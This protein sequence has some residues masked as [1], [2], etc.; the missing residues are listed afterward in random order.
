LQAC[1]SDYVLAG[2]VL[3]PVQDGMWCG[4]WKS[5]ENTTD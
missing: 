4:V 2:L 3:W 1:R 5:K